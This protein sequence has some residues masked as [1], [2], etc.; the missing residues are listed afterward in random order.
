MPSSFTAT[1]ADSGCGVTSPLTFS[2]PASLTR[3]SSATFTDLA[4]SK[5]AP[6]TLSDSGANSTVAAGDVLR[7]SAEILASRRVNSRKSKLQGAAEGGGGA[8]GTGAA[9]GAAPL[10]TA[11]GAASA[12]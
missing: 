4:R 8:A 12:A 7:S 2:E 9:G 10:A 11:A 5:L 6:V 3:V 1:L